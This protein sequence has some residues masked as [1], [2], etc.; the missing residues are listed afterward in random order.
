MN[1]I[2]K[3][4]R[5]RHLGKSLPEVY[6]LP[7]GGAYFSS[8]LNASSCIW[9]SVQ[10]LLIT[11][12]ISMK[13]YEE[14]DYENGCSCREAGS[15]SKHNSPGGISHRKQWMFMDRRIKVLWVWPHCAWYFT[16]YFLIFS[17]N[18]FCP[19]KNR[20]GSNLSFK[21]ISPVIQSVCLLNAF[22]S[23]CSSVKRTALLL[24]PSLNTHGKR[25][26]ILCP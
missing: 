7:W 5:W 26:P 12:L 21:M 3:Q 17:L 15:Y 23:I 18:S 8:V 2:T 22:F 25:F 14:A 24:K 20:F 6:V 1:Q 9:C 19:T 10:S 11:P 16:E 13:N 4:D